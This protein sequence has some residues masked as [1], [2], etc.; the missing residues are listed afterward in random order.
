MDY[1]LTRSNRKTLALYVRDGTVE[2]RAPLKTPKCDIDRFVSS[3]DKWIRDKLTKSNEQKAR[4]DSFT[5]HYGDTVTVRGKQYPITAR[6]G[7]RIG[8]DGE[9][10]YIPPELPPDEIKNT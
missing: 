9:H 6:N 7:N 8:F 1:T 2:V 10:F 3:K 4:R 5:L